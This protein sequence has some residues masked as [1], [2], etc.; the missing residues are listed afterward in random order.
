LDKRVWGEGVEALQ[1]EVCFRSNPR[2]VH[3]W[4]VGRAR[5]SRSEGNLRKLRLVLVRVRAWCVLRFS[6]VF[7]GF[8]GKRFSREFGPEITKLEGFL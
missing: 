3:F 1:V 8:G 5:R 2:K 6:C 7:S 4:V